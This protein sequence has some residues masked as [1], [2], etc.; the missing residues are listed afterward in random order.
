MSSL[1]NSFDTPRRHPR[2]P[3]DRPGLLEIVVATSVT[4]VRT[5]P[6][7]LSVPVRVRDVSLGGLSVVFL[8]SFADGVELK[9]EM[10]VIV[11]FAIDGRQVELTG[12]LVW[13]LKLPGSKDPLLAGIRLRLETV[14]SVIRTCYEGWV[15]KK[16]AEPRVQ[17]GTIEDRGAGSLPTINPEELEPIEDTDRELLREIAK[18]RSLLRRALEHM[19]T[20]D[21]ADEITR[22][23]E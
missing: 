12:A 5:P 13:N 16:M 4:L 21:L 23:L 10:P 19:P 20:G 15:R 8:D 1:A 3:T 11:R 2:V 18:A 22:W 14:S 9:P 7:R 6:R 17:R